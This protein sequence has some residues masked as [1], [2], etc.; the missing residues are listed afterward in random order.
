MEV[1]TPSFGLRPH[2]GQSNLRTIVIVLGF[3]PHCGENEK[4]RQQKGSR[5]FKA[6]K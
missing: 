1:I 4:V 6:T 5:E 2:S 3:L